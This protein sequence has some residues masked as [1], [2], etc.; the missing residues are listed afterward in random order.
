[1]AWEG[2]V[3]SLKGQPDGVP[4]GDDI[5]HGSPADPAWSSSMFTIEQ[6]L[7]VKHPLQSVVLKRT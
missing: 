2:F 6:I 3:S 5:I 4:I 1:M 7:N